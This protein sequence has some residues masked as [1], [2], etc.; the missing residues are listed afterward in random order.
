M[1]GGN[2]ETWRHQRDEV[3]LEDFSIS[4][5]I[6]GTKGRDPDYELMTYLVVIL[7]FLLIKLLA[8]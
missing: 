7:S 2:L 3:N 4:S 5:F 1:L 6:C 8:M